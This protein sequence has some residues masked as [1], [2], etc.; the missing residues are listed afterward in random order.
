MTTSNHV[1]SAF[2]FISF[3]IVSISLPW[4]LQAGNTATCLYIVWVSLS[5]LTLFVNSVLWDGNVVD[6]SPIWC[7]ISGR[8]IIATY[9]AIPATCLCIQR[10]VYHILSDPIAGST[11]TKARHRVVWD[12]VIGLGL[13]LLSLVFAYV[14]QPSRYVIYEDLGCRI[15]FKDYAPATALIPTWRLGLGII[16]GVYGCMNMRYIW[17]KRQDIQTIMSSSTG[18]VGYNHYLKLF[19]LS[20]IDILITIPYNVWSFT[21]WFPISPWPGWKAVHSWSKI[22][23]IPAS[24]WRTNP[25]TNWMCELGRWISV[26]YAFAFFLFFGVGAEVRRDYKS[27]WD[28]VS[29]KFCWQRGSS[30]TSSRA[31][32]SHRTIYTDIIF[33]KTEHSHSDPIDCSESLCGNGVNVVAPLTVSNS[34]F[35]TEKGLEFASPED[36]AHL[37]PAS[38]QYCIT[39]LPS[40]TPPDLESGGWIRPLVL[41]DSKPEF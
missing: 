14:V 36:V 1:F 41:K 37:K 8:Q 26:V 38:Q 23:V 7:D 31:S 33:A 18:S 5:N 39:T 27:A 28:Y 22:P 6:R 11:T 35:K 24:V 3:I 17:N 20:G 21:T 34:D 25:S 40:L 29:K 2:S 4:H 30:Q 12:L 16:S 13:P 15:I 19:V 10:L 9:V 32:E